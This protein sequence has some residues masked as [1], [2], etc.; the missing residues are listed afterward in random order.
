MVDC[1]EGGSS[2]IISRVRL[3]CFGTPSKD[4]L[5]TKRKVVKDL[6]LLH[7]LPVSEKDTEVVLCV[8]GGKA[9]PSS[10]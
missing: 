9:A 6:L 5:K 4:F 2:I 1:I 3:V 8:D 10:H 7:A